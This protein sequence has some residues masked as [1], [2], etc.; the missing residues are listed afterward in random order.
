M[1]IAVTSPKLIVDEIRYL[2]QWPILPNGSKSIDIDKF[3][4]GLAACSSSDIVAIDKI[5]RW[6]GCYVGYCMA[7]GIK[8]VLVRIKEDAY[9]G[10]YTRF[11]KNR[12]G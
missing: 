9:Y 12:V 10:A 4:K 6:A 7:H 8:F 11:T 5:N 3:R 1:I 2:H